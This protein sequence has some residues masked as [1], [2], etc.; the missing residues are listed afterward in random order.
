MRA[1]QSN[2]LYSKKTEDII[3]FIKTKIPRSFIASGEFYNIC[4]KYINLRL[5]HD[6][7]SS[8][9]LTYHNS[10]CTYYSKIRY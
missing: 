7:C 1:C 10:N 8:L 5:S 6:K 3:P 4:K 9:F 2:E